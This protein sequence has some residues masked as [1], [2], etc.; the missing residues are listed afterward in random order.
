MN[1]QPVSTATASLASQVLRNPASLPRQD[2]TQ[3]QAEDPFSAYLLSL[4]DPAAIAEAALTSLANSSTTASSAAAAANL[5]KALGAGTAG[6]SAAGAVTLAAS[7]IRQLP[8]LN[9]PDPKQN[10]PSQPRQKGLHS[11]QQD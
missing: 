8:A 11:T 3:F 4:S 10:H 9:S 6:T 5:G 1:T 2:L 7:L